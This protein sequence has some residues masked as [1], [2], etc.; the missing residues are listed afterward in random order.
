MKQ[1]AR[2]KI[3]KS[4]VNLMESYAPE[5][6]TIKMICAYG[7]I[8][9]STFYAYFLDKYDSKLSHGSLSTINVHHLSRF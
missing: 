3:F 1:R 6:I 9:R 8:N 4:T 2:I 5:E 7:G